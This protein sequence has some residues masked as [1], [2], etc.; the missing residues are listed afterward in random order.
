M[1]ITS[2]TC[3]TTTSGQLACNQ[4]KKTQQDGLHFQEFLLWSLW[5]SSQMIFAS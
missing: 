5:T 2:A 4:I 3:K 1:S